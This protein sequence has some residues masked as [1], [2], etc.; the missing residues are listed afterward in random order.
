MVALGFIPI[1]IQLP[2]NLYIDRYILY[3]STIET[4]ADFIIINFNGV[5]LL[6]A[7]NGFSRFFTPG[8]FTRLGSFIIF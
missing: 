7:T 5:A 8:S 1:S 4:R 3:I 6:R 2:D